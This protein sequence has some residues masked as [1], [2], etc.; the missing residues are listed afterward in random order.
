VRLA[1][2]E[3]M[4]LLAG[5]LGV[6]F[7][8]EKL[9]SLCMTWLIDHVF[10]IREAATNNLKKL[11]EN[12]GTEWAQQTVIPKVS[13]VRMVTNTTNTNP[14]LMQIQLD[15]PGGGYV[16]GP[17]LPA[18]HDLPLLHQRAGHGLRAGD[19]RATAAALLPRPPHGPG[20]PGDSAGGLEAALAF[21]MSA[22]G[23][24]TAVTSPN[25]TKVTVKLAANFLVH[26]LN[27]YA[28]ALNVIEV[29]LAEHESSYELYN[30]KLKIVEKN[31]IIEEII[32]VCDN[33]V[34]NVG[35]AGEKEYFV[36]QK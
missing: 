17:E 23:V 3:Y 32:D 31:G 18:P 7:F 28:E 21:Y 35:S 20:G 16:P 11:V 14:N 9:N 26:R 5:Q 15:V 4:P 22:Q 1:I 25:I 34:D 10:A 29:G 12:F 33:A 13:S 6:D 30:I 27:D 24:S 2:I 8:D 19:H 36:Y